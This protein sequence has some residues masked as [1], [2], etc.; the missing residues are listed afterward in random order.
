[1]SMVV[2][3]IFK[4]VY[5]SLS[6][7]WNPGLIR[8]IFKYSLNSVKARIISLSLIVFIAVFSMV[9]QP[10]TCMTNMYLF[11]LVYVVGKHPH[12]YE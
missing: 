9:L 10:Y 11:T 8:R 12:M 1:M 2:I 4:D 3:V 7:K 6:M 5:Y